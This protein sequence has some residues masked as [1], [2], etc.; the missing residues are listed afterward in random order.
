[1]NEVH[2][3]SE[4]ADWETPQRLFDQLDYE[5]RFTL[6]AAASDADT[7]VP[8]RYYTIRDNALVQNWAEDAHLFGLG[9]AGAVWCNPP[10]GRVIGAFVRK[11]WEESQKGVTVVMLLPARTDTSWWHDY[12]MK[13]DEVRLIRGRLRFVGAENCAPFPSCVVVFRPDDE[14]IPPESPVKFSAISTEGK[15]LR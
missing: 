14:R 12:V 2:Y 7:K 10:Y 5:F 4:R 11:G 3:S 9:L 6:D 15:R 8:G 13:A 1:M